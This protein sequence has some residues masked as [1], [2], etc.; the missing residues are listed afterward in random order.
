MWI[1]N[2]SVSS[3]RVEGVEEACFGV[4]YMYILIWHLTS[5]IKG[6]YTDLRLATLHTLVLADEIAHIDL[7]I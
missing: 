3:E 6:T 4:L 2:S 1:E 5:K 7:A